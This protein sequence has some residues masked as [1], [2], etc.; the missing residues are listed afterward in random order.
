M[1]KEREKERIKERKKEKERMKE[2]K[3]EGKKERKGCFLFLYFEMTT[4]TRG[5]HSNSHT[6]GMN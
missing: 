2:R 4:A 6:I 1:K 3:K 5:V